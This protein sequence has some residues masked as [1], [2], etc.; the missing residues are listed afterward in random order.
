MTQFLVW[1]GSE[2]FLHTMTTYLKLIVLCKASFL[3][4]IPKLSHGVDKKFYPSPSLSRHVILG[5]LLNHTSLFSRCK[6]G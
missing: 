1:A 4:I 2:S 3:H 6:I 5:K